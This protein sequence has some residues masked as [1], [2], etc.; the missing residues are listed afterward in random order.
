M[1]NSYLF[2]IIRNL[3]FHNSDM[4]SFLTIKK[5]IIFPMTCRFFCLSIKP[6]SSISFYS[7]LYHSIVINNQISIMTLVFG[8]KNMFFFS[9]WNRSN[10]YTFGIIQQLISKLNTYASFT[11]TPLNPKRKKK[12]LHLKL[13]NRYYVYVLREK[14]E[15][16]KILSHKLSLCIKFYF[17]SKQ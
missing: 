11:C 4:F 3:F 7:I 8:K 1:Y 14:T 6:Q 15:T 2:T 17:E 16:D 10:R 9:L 12:E 5:I 13:R